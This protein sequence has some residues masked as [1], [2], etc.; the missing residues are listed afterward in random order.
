MTA[1]DKSNLSNTPKDVP[2][3]EDNS[4]LEPTEGDP[5]R[6]ADPSPESFTDDK[7]QEDPEDAS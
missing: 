5:A 2:V 4:V 6:S 7:E 3:D 1:E